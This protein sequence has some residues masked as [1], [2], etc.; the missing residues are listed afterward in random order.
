VMQRDRFAHAA[1]AQDAD[2]LSRQDVEADVFKY[3]TVSEGLGDVAKLDVGR[4][5]GVRH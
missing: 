1:A 3:A 5:R 4:G 2:G